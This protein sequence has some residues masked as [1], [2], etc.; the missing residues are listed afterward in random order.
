MRG[1]LSQGVCWPTESDDADIGGRMNIPT[2]APAHVRAGW[3]V[4]IDGLTPR[5][6]QP[7]NPDPSQGRR[8]GYQATASTGLVSAVALR[9]LG[10][11][12]ERPTPCQSWMS[13]VDP[14]ERWSSLKVLL[15]RAQSRL[16]PCR[17]L[18]AGVVAGT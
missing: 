1:G 12:R 7:G 3:P 4:L 14:A 5:P 18:R 16:L 11:N 10:S 2:F 15:L 8:C 13:D 9:E 6:I 17:R